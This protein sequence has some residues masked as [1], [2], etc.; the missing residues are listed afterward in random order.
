VR[1][2][3]SHAHRSAAGWA[4]SLAL[5]P[6]GLRIITGFTN[7]YLDFGFTSIDAQGQET[8]FVAKLPD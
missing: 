8:F 2:G 1:S 3:G 6:S 4:D 5:D 7:G